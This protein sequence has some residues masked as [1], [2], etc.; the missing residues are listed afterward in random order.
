M[1]ELPLL[2]WRLVPMDRKEAFKKGVISQ[3]QWDHM[4]EDAQYYCV[5]AIAEVEEV[6]LYTLVATTETEDE[7]IVISTYE[8]AYWCPEVHIHIKEDNDECNESTD[9]DDAI[10]DVVR[11]CLVEDSG[12]HEGHQADP[13]QSKN[14]TKQRSG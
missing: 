9:G 7:S 11:G 10:R 13:D 4:C 5:I 1:R 6:Q 14:K 12:D 3:K 2:P 8:M